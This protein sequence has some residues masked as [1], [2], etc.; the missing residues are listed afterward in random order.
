MKP[1][2][3]DVVEVGGGAKVLLFKDDAGRLTIGLT[4]NDD[5]VREIKKPNSLPI[6]S[7]MRMKTMMVDESHLRGL[8]ELLDRRY[9]THK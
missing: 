5:G 4:Y 3:G 2:E 8:R 7:S 1:T 6:T 9:G